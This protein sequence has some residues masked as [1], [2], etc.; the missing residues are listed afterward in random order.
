MNADLEPRARMHAALGEPVRLAIIDQLRLG[1]GSPGDLATAFGVATNLLAHHLGVLE[2]AGLVRRVRSEGDRRR[3]Y[4]QLCL[5]DQ[6]LGTLSGTPPVLQVTRVVFVCTHNAA[7]SQLAVAAWKRAHS[8]PAASAGTR[9]AARVHPRTV[10]TGRRHGLRLANARTADVAD[11]LR[12]DDLVVAVC[13]NAYEGLDAATVSRSLHWAVPDPVRIDTDAAFERTYRD[14]AE[15]VEQLTHAVTPVHDN[16]A[17]L[18]T[19]EL[20][21]AP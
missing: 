21:S 2:G 4:V 17:A 5:G 18:A 12:P 13:D 19:P 15:R 8:V 11:V 10:S 7:R 14:I 6:V 1:D 20:R 9:P 16:P 3:T